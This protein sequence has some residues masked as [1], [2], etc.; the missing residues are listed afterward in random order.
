MKKVTFTTIATL[1]S[2]AACG[3]EPTSELNDKASPE[4]ASSDVTTEVTQ[5]PTIQNPFYIERSCRRIHLERETASQALNDVKALAEESRWRSYRV[6][7][8]ELK[9]GNYIAAENLENYYKNPEAF[10]RR[11]TWFISNKDPFRDLSGGDYLRCT[12]GSDIVRDTGTRFANNGRTSG[13]K[14]GQFT[15]GLASAIVNVA[16]NT[17]TPSASNTT[18]SSSEPYRAI[19]VEGNG[20]FSGICNDGRSAFSGS[21]FDGLYTVAASGKSTVLMANRNAGI[22][23]ACGG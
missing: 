23:A 22:R 8:Y 5:N 18:R 21:Y 7:I 12:D 6:G 4:P 15:A 11:R 14:S 16:T 19:T 13:A 10:K 17:N 9:N 1:L 2:L 20:S 3:A